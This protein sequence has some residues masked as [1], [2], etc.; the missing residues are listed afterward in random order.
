MEEEWRPVVDFEGYYEVSNLGNIRSVDRT[1]ISSNG[2]ELH[3]KGKHIT[4]G[5]DKDGYT[6]YGLYVNSKQTRVKAH[7]EVAKAFLPNPDGLPVVNHKDENKLNNRVDNLEWCTV[8]Y[9][10]KYGSRLGKM[11]KSESQPV[12]QYTLTGKFVHRYSSLADAARSLGKSSS[13]SIWSACNR[14]QKT[15]YGYVWK[16]V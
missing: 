15:A 1:V 5:I 8:D 7:R 12:A 14:K 13:G 3:Y 9:N 11:V 6:T 16:Y 4:P 10:N 2:K